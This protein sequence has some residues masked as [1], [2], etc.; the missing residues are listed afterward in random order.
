MKSGFSTRAG[1]KP[2]LIIFLIML[3]AFL[4]ACQPKVP[5]V[6]LALLGDLMLGRSVDPAPSSLAYLAPDL[7]AADLALANL[8]SPL[9][10][11]LPAS[12]PTTYNLCT[13]S[14]RAD[15]LPAWGIDLV[16]LA[17]NHSLDCGPDGP[18]E[19]RSALDEAGITAIGPGMEPV[20]REVNGLGLAFL[21]FD[22]ISS[23]LDENAAVQAIRSAH[24]TGALV[25]VSIH[26]GAEYQGGASDRQ[27]SL[28]QEFAEAGAALVWGHHPHV[29][30]PAMWIHPPA[31]S[32]PA[33]DSTLVLYSLGN[34]LFDQ[35]GLDDTRQSAL[36]VVTLDAHGV[37]GVRSVPFEID[38]IN[39]RVI[40]PDAAAAEKILD[41]L[42][43]P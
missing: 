19:T 18:A 14:A 29:L 38:V 8:E 23:P 36:V 22:D 16:S 31:G 1:L 20:S 42:N 17:N 15:L 39:S 2:A 28:A 35:G 13:L 11:V 24:A 4:A 10:P 27:K 26:W 37:T 34:A 9:A 6:T 32:E 43:L 12:D 7:P 21:A 5:T 41:R 25:I 3:A 33:G 40:Q 30:Q